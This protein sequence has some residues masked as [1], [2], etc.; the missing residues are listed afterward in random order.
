MF[1]RHVCEIGGIQGENGDVQGD[2]RVL[3]DGAM[4]INWSIKFVTYLNIMVT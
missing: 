4:E 3:Q 1:L 2:K